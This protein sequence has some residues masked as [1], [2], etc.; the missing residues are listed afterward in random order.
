[1]KSTLILVSLLTAGAQLAAFCKLWFTVRIFGLSPELDAYYLALTVPTMVSGVISGILQ[2]GLFPVRARLNLEKNK[3][4]VDAFERSVLA[5]ASIFALVI[6]V[7]LGLSIPYAPHL[8]AGKATS[9]VQGSVAIAFPWL[10]LL[11]PLNVLS[12]CCGY[13][14]AMRNR[15]AIAAAAPIANGLLGAVL[16]AAW[17]SGGFANLIIGTLA[18]FLLQVLICIIGLNK[19]GLRIFGKLPGLMAIFLHWKDVGLLGVKILPA[20]I[21]ASLLTA[22]PPL[23]LASFGEGAISAFGYA[24]RLHSSAVQLLIMAS[25]TVILAEFSELVAQ[26][27]IK[28]IRRILYKAAAAGI[29]VGVLVVILVDTIGSDVLMLLFGGKFDLPVATKVTEHWL[30]LSLGMPFIIFSNVL[31]KLWQAQRRPLLMSALGMVNLSALFLAFPLLR[32]WVGEFSVAGALTVGTM[33]MAILGLLVT[34]K[35][36]SARQAYRI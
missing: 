17:P 2:T 19:S 29:V 22:M 33:I 6:L 18:G 20:V 10:L 34:W 13:L 25:T 26:N 28:A 12:D 31:A 4:E 11:L 32:H 5:G 23:W 16:F 30:W 24:Y 21:V 27:D 9:S 3:D 35:S 14:L 7:F 36:V 1:M 15:F 8:L